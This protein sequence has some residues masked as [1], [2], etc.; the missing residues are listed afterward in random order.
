[1]SHS[2]IMRLIVQQVN[3]HGVTRQLIAPGGRQVLKLD[4]RTEGASVHAHKSTG[5]DRI[6]REE[7][8]LLKRGSGEGALLD[9]NLRRREEQPS[10]SSSRAFPLDFAGKK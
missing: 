4:A 2:L 5:G 6:G 3:L 7:S 10:L 9:S 8:G 1:M